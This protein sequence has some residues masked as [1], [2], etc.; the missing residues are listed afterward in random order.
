[1]RNYKFC[2][3]AGLFLLALMI[4]LPF[5]ASI[6][7]ARLASIV[8][9]AASLSAFCLVIAM[10]RSAR[11]KFHWYESLLDA[12]PLPLSVTDNEMR[13]TFV[14]KVVEDLLQKK[15]SQIVGMACSNWGAN[16]CK[17]EDCGVTC[18]RRGQADTTFHQ[19]S[20]DFIVTT[21]YLKNL[22][23]R[24]VGHIEVV[25]DVSEKIALERATRKTAEGMEHLS[26]LLRAFEGQAIDLVSQSASGTAELQAT[27]ESLAGTAAETNRQTE[28]VTAAANQAAVNVQT[29]A[30]AAEELASSIAE[31][32]HQVAQSAAKT[33]RAASDAQRTDAVVRALAEGA[34]K[35]G[36][37]VG[38]INVIAGQ[39][40]LLALNATIEA[41]RAGEA[42]KGFAVVASEVKNLAQQ[43]ARATGEIGEQIGRVQAATQQAVEAITGIAASVAEV[44]TI[45]TAIAAAVEEQGGATAEI[46]RNAAEAAQ[47]TQDVTAGL[48][49]LT[50]G[51]GETGVAA[52]QV[53]NAASSLSHHAEMLQREVRG[54]LQNAR[55][56]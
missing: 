4:A 3:R 8:I 26:G 14:N 1:M 21:G 55:A 15:R 44:S 52:N 37:V 30:A 18:L 47:G 38:L 48:A 9:G 25:Q 45:A 54:F 29:V 50:R 49:D 41:A 43:T 34:R 10:D 20:R 53:L 22:S 19:W 17:T 11:E 51:A 42:G 5:S 27:A 2:H 24:P 33:E 12:V 36:D 16:I 28:N 31:V 40:N 23:D 46:A 13:W 56:A 6:V 39:T 7:G 32:G 35:I